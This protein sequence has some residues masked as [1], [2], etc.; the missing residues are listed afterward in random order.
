MAWLSRNGAP[1]GL[2]AS[3]ANAISEVH[4][5]ISVQFTTLE[6]QV[7]ASLTRPRLLAVLS[8]FF[9]A[10]ALLLAMLG[11]YGTLAYRV[12]SR[13]NEIGVRLALGAARTRVVAMVL[14]EVGRLVI[15]GV[16]IGIALTIAATR[17]LKSF[18]FGVTA[19]DP[20]TVVLSAATLAFVAVLAGAIA[21]W[22]AARIDP[23]ETL[24]E[25]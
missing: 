3:V 5:R 16:A 14:S 9:G 1:S 24:R 11:L 7:S 2:I 15:F 4:P 6:E 10:V 20:T 12:T 8:G 21:A 23:M 17:L 22:H 19:T 18:L 25:E 13:R